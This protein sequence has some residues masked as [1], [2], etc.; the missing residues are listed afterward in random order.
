MRTDCGARGSALLIV[1][2][3]LA[4]GTAVGVA[5]MD[6]VSEEQR[7]ADNREGAMQALNIALGG[8]GLAKREL[9]HDA[10]WPGGTALP[11]G[12]GESFD[13]EVTPVSANER[14]VLATGRVGEFERAV[15]ARLLLGDTFVV[16]DESVAP[17]SWRER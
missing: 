15:E 7:I 9:A 10:A 6:L 16:G 11:F 5:L 14:R 13:V 3:V 12:A 4:L 1:L 17:G 8:L 2:L